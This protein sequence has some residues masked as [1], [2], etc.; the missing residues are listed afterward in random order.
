VTTGHYK[1]ITGKRYLNQNREA[2]L[3]FTHNGDVEIDR[4]AVGVP[5]TDKSNIAR[6]G[7]AADIHCAGNTWW[8]P[9][10]TVQSKAEKFDHPA[11]FPVELPERCIKLHGVKDG[12]VVLDPFLGAGTTLVAAQ[13]LGC[14]GI[15]IEIDPTYCEVARRR[16]DILKG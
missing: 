8:I 6:R 4:L 9:Y 1:P 12:L 7:H 15:G 2:I 13:Q 3:H 11:G 10:A 14:Q 16:L 5:F